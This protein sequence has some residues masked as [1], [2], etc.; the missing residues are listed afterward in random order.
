MWHIALREQHEEENT[1]SDTIH[2]GSKPAGVLNDDLVPEVP[3]G[4]RSHRPTAPLRPDETQPTNSAGLYAQQPENPNPAQSMP[5]QDTADS[6]VDLTPTNDLDLKEQFMPQALHT[7]GDPLLPVYSTSPQR[8]EL[9][10]TRSREKARQK[11]IEALHNLTEKRESVLGLRLR[12]HEARNSLRHDRETLSN[13]DAQLVQRLRAAIANNSLAEQ[14]PLVD[15]LED[16]QKSRDS[17]Q[18]KEDN[19]NRLEDQLNRE[20]WELKEMELRLYQR[21]GS[22]QISLLGDDGVGLFEGAFDET[23]SSS[24]LSI[25]SGPAEDSPETKR[26]LSRRG[27][28]TLLREQIADMRAMKAQIIEDEAVRKRLGHTLDEESQSFLDNFDS[29]LE[30][31]LEDLANVEEDI[32]R[33]QEALAEKHVTFLSNPFDGKDW[34]APTHYAPEAI[35]SDFPTGPAAES[36]ST[37]F[38]VLTQDPLLLPVDRREHVLFDSSD[39]ATSNVISTPGY[40]NRWLLHSLR[41][42]IPE[43]RRYKSAEELKQ[44]RLKFDQ[45]QIKDFV[46]DWWYKDQSVAD[47]RVARNTAALSLGLPLSPT[48]IYRAGARSE[49]ATPI[50]H[51]LLARAPPEMSP[52]TLV[53]K[54]VP[55][56]QS[57]DALSLDSPRTIH[58][59]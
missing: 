20:E 8:V 52:T 15:E 32:S 40:I 14:T 41:R 25:H 43:V 27:D 17:L 59:S 50:V 58:Q 37:E 36:A 9:A 1:V 35:L 53:P 28:A 39:P 10:N 26:Y 11:R 49:T 18:P 24:S 23:D 38:E 13:R 42:S 21:G 45:E 30:P 48:H 47:F 33:L 55:V 2:A 19:Y 6:G 16:L 54:A 34:D 12:V 22:T 44:L 51:E 3:G 4:E 46:L 57:Y 29:R 7:E 56:L 31:L 5:R